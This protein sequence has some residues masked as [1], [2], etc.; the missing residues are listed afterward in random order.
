VGFYGV[1]DREGSRVQRRTMQIQVSE[2]F[3]GLVGRGVV[4][5]LDTFHVEF[6]IAEAKL[7]DRCKV[8]VKFEVR[9]DAIA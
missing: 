3:F 8:F 4:F 5:G 6:H 9:E 7:P 1:G 2:E